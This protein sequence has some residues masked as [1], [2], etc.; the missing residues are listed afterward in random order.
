MRIREDK[1]TRTYVTGNFDKFVVLYDG[2]AYW[3]KMKDQY[4]YCI[5]TE[6]DFHKESADITIAVRQYSEIKGSIVSLKRLLKM[7]EF[8]VAHPV[9][10]SGRHRLGIE[11]LSRK[12]E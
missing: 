4:L 9:D 5:S 11:L 3:F 7:R 1:E 6:E 8:Y 10:N 12:G 2:L